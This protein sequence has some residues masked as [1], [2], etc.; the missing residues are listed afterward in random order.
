[1][2]LK[3]SLSK[4]NPRHWFKDTTVRRIYGNASVLVSGKVMAGLMSPVYVSLAAHTLGTTQFGVLVLVNAYTLSIA[5]LITLQG[6][7]ALVRYATLC[8]AEESFSKLKNLLAFML[9]L[10]LGFGVLAIGAAALLAPYAAEQFSWPVESLPYIVLYSL[11]CA[12]MMHSMPAGVLFVFGRFNLLSIQQTMGPLV[13]VAGAA[14]AYV[15]ESGLN[16]FLLAWLAGTLAEAAAQWFF[17]LRELSRRGLL[18]SLLKWPRGVTREHPGLWRFLLTNKLNVSLE[19]LSGRATPLAV[20]WLLGPAAAGLYQIA[21]K[22]GMI[23]AQPVL[24][25]GQS[26][27]PE[28]SQLVADQRFAELRRVV[29]RTGL[30]AAMLGMCV[31]IVLGFFGGNILVLM[32]GAGFDAAYA[33]LMMITLARTLH[34]LGFPLASALIA[35]GKPGAVLKVN[36]VAMLVL[37]PI[38]FGLLHVYGLRGAGLHA[39]LFAV[40]SVA[41]MA[42]V[43]RQQMPVRPPHEHHTH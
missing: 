18:K 42:A 41:W 9:L 26:L 23:L 20:G 15:L 2:T 30:I 24:V 28:L 25:I 36:L 34:L 12:S 17:G 38:L 37:L 13:R 29:V 11:A 43:F 19:E 14:L 32:G 33:V 35:F 27:Y 3:N 6:R 16:G 10:E 8:L 4:V 21:L 7:Y 39:L 1:M 31:L 40:F 22:I 5:A